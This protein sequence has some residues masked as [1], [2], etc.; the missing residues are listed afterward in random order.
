MEAIC[1][2]IS[3][4]NTLSTQIKYL[5]SYYIKEVS[6]HYSENFGPHLVF[7]GT[8]LVNFGLT[9]AFLRTVIHQILF[10]N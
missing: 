10:L 3:H 7:N 8:D 2:S 9:C 4:F 5:K 6:F 1:Y